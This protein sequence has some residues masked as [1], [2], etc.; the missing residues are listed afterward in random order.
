MTGRRCNKK[1]P[2]GQHSLIVI[3]THL[4][5]AIFSVKF[6]GNYGNSKGKLMPQWV[7][8]L[9]DRY[10]INSCRESTKPFWTSIFSSLNWWSWQAS[11]E[12]LSQFLATYLEKFSCLWADSYSS[13]CKEI[14]CDCIY[15]NACSSCLHKYTVKN[16][17]CHYLW[18]V[19]K[20]K[21]LGQ[22]GESQG[23]VINWSNLN[24]HSGNW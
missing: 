7:L 17:Q 6:K 3:C 15:E 16:C 9:S 10:L 8:L 5:C 24:S 19:Y 14:R 4:F 22:K 21:S 20:E 18:F 12:A 23:G 2:C 13:F 11:D 1:V